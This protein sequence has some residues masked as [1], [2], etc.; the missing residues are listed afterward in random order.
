M[1]L[2]NKDIFDITQVEFAVVEGHGQLSVLKKS[3]FLHVSAKD[4]GLPTNY[5]GM[6]SE[7]II[8]GDVIEQ[9]LRQNKLDFR[10]LYQE[11]TKKVED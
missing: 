8:R 3:Q 9:Y 10:W 2:R 11:L 6:A 1:Q 4:L 5:K 7:I